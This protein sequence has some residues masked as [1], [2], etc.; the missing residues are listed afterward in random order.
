MSRLD[1]VVGSNGAG[2]STFVERVIL[3]RWPSALLVNA[4]LIAR[5][6][7]PRDLEAHSYEAA[8]IAAA[9]RDRLIETGRPFIAETVFS[10]ESKLELVARA[11]AAGYHL[12]LHVLMV[13]EAVAVHRVALRVQRGG[14]S[15]P[16]DKIRERY[17]RLWPLVVE[18]IEQSDVA[19]IY[20][21]NAL[22]GP[23]EAASFAGGL[24]TGVP[25]WPNWTPE[26]MA[27]R[28]PRVPSAG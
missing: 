16:E 28:W 14:H 10:H 23:V 6:K 1:L 18:A 12:A 22:G 3:P 8:R 20:D 7:W 26:G 24:P 15:V 13:P 25:A 19:T 2:K 17:H 4:N 11:R 5:Q 9:T 21:N 27:A